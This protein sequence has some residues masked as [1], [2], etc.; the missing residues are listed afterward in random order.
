MSKH[1][2]ILCHRDG[3]CEVVRAFHEQVKGDGQLEPARQ[4]K[5]L[6]ATAQIRPQ[7]TLIHSGLSQLV[8][9]R[10]Y[11]PGLKQPV[12]ATFH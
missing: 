10:E 2:H 5:H 12:Q 9:G 3:K 1:N 11:R 8:V 4:C 6:T 7:R